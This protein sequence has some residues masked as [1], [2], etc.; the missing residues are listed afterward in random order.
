LKCRDSNIWSF[1]F[2]HLQ[3]KRWRS[4]KTKFS[5]TSVLAIPS[6]QM[7]FFEKIKNIKMKIKRQQ[8]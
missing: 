1:F 5:S 8:E 6:S 3:C 7:V 4:S 2:K